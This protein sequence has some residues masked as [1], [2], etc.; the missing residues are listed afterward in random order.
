MIVALLLAAASGAESPTICADRP[1]Q[2]TGTCTVPAGHFQ[3]ETGLADWS[4]EK[5]SG[6]RD[7]SLTL[8]ETTI[9]YGLTDRSNLEIDVTPFEKVESRG[10]GESDEHSGFGD[11]NFLYKYR[12]TGSG[13]ALQAALLPLIKVP[14]AKRPLGNGK[15]EGALLIPIGY[16]IA[17]SP[18]SLALTPEVD[19]TADSDGH[20]H[21]AA[22]V[23][24]A[25]FGWQATERLNLSGEI[26]VQ[27]NWD[28]A[29][30]T[31]EASLDGSAAFLASNRVQLDAG[32][33][34]GLNRETPDV[35]LYSGVSMLF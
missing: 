14:I 11:I 21:H 10:G 23:Q 2:A 32:A 24:V 12:L 4:V 7:T 34:F 6:E 17:G 9:K 27:W 25:S 29:G 3:V 30:T 15:L 28:P 19:W 18:F 5:D 16:S 33:R 20:G 8:G 13:A 1:G 35:E 22:M 31:R 26:W